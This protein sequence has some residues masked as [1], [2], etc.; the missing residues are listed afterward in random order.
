MKFKYC[1]KCLIVTPHK[2]K[3]IPIER[4]GHIIGSKFVEVCTMCK[5]ES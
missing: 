2:I 1:R 4:N 5:R 3:Q